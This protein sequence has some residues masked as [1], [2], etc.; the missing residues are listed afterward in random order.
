[1]VIVCLIRELEIDK[2]GW[3]I[4]KL[5][6]EFRIQSIGPSR[7][8]LFARK[9]TTHFSKIEKLLKI[10]GGCVEMSED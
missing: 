8:K 3:Q 4:F 5:S 1:M 6:A 7:Q 2:K 9:R 10:G